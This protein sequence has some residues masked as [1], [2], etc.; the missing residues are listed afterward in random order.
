M[1]V[2]LDTFKLGCCL[3]CGL[4]GVFL[5]VVA[6]LIADIEYFELLDLNI[7][8]LRIAVGALVVPIPVAISVCG[9]AGAVLFAAGFIFASRSS[10]TN[11]T[12]E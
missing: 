11:S 1:K 10:L 4:A 7:H 9:G 6:L 2:I 3:L 8:D 5:S 12:T